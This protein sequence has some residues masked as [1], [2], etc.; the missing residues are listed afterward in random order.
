MPFFT[1]EK[2]IVDLRCETKASMVVEKASLR[3]NW[4]LE[5]AQGYEKGKKTES[6]EQDNKRSNNSC[7]LFSGEYVETD[8]YRFRRWLIPKSYVWDY[9]IPTTNE[10]YCCHSVF[11]SRLHILRISDNLYLKNN[12]LLEVLKFLIL[13][14]KLVTCIVENI[15]IEQ[16]SLL[17]A[18][19]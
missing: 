15:S 11:S 16:I 17:V 13:S 3:L 6:E 19:V 12:T 7:R 2:R 4:S 10:L 5:M 14:T 9:W 8:E 1:K 18:N